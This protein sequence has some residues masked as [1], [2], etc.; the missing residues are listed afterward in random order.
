M[1]GYG[2]KTQQELG[3]NDKNNGINRNK[4]KREPHEV[5]L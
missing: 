3:V 5:Y 4:T 1:A 2:L